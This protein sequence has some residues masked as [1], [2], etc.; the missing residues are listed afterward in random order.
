MNDK[1]HVTGYGIGFLLVEGN[2]LERTDLSPIE[3]L[4]L[5]YD[6]GNETPL[7]SDESCAECLGITTEQVTRARNHLNEL[8]EFVEPHRNSDLSE[9]EYYV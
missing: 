1:R 3:K 2:L 4:V 5:A 7:T 8:G 9:G 6:L